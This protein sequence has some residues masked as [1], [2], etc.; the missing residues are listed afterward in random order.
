MIECCLTLVGF[1]IW[2]RSVGWWGWGVG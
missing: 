1:S 2:I